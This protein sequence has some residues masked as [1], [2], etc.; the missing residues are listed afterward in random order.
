M[1][2]SSRITD[3]EGKV[4]TIEQ[5]ANSI[6]AIVGQ[7][8]IKITELSTELSGTVKFTNLTDGVTEI[9]GSNIKTGTIN[10]IDITG[11]TITSSGAVSSTT[12]F[13]PATATLSSSVLQFLSV[14]S[15]GGTTVATISAADGMTISCNQSI[16]INGGG[17]LIALQNGMVGIS[18]LGNIEIYRS[19]QLY[20]NIDSGNIYQYISSLP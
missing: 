20:V 9:S 19:G 16:F 10:A 8:G 3:A 17:S 1:L 6:S 5:T 4:S 13:V 12:G 7:Q 18:A 11:C 15:Y 14:N 2:L